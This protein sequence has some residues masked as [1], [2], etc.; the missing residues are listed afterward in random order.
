MEAY[1]YVEVLN[2][3]LDETAHKI[4][5]LQRHVLALRTAHVEQPTAATLEDSAALQTEQAWWAQAHQR[6]L[7]ARD[8]LAQIARAEE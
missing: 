3:L 7:L 6:L 1:Q 5:Q 4:E 2:F 8:A